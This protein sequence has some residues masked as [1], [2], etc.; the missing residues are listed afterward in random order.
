M[1]N[2]PFIAWELYERSFD[3]LGKYVRN[4]GW[5]KTEKAAN[6]AAIKLVGTPH[7]IQ[8]RW[9]IELESGEVYELKHVDPVYFGLKRK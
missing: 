3:E 4:L 7:G 5:F 1:I 2:E 6:D 8:S 9:V